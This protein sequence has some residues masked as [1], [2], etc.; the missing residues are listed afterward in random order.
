M[1]IFLGYKIVFIKEIVG[2]PEGKVRHLLDRFIYF[3]PENM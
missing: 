2:R 3:V 1:V